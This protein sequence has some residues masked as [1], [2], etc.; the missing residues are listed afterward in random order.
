[1]FDTLMMVSMLSPFAESKV[2]IY[3]HY[4]FLGVICKYIIKR[5]IGGDG[6]VE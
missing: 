4:M 3:L 6:Y 1:M 5:L 2:I